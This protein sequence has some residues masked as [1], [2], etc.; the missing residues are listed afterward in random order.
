MNDKNKV[1]V[2]VVYYELH[3][4]QAT[5]VFVATTDRII[6]FEMPYFDTDC[7]MIWAGLHFSCSEPSI[8]VASMN[9]LIQHHSH[10]RPLHLLA[11]N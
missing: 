6:S 11:I 3:V 8:L 10:W 2:S 1:T 4:S 7:E 9:L 5:V